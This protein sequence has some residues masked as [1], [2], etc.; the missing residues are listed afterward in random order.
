[1]FFRPFPGSMPTCTPESVAEPRLDMELG[2]AHWERRKGRWG[3]GTRAKWAT[4]ARSPQGKE[5]SLGCSPAWQ[6][7]GGNW[8]EG[9]SLRQW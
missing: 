3:S 2:S 4:P 5:V 1:M 9:V 8:S 7:R 6:T